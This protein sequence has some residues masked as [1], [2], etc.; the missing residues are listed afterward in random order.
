VAR[1]SKTP[2]IVSS[3][4]NYT[5][6]RKLAKRIGIKPTQLRK[7]QSGEVKPSKSEISKIS[8]L[9]KLIPQE[10]KLK[11][12]IKR[13]KML[14]ISLAE[15]KSAR[16]A[17]TLKEIEQFNKAVARRE[18]KHALTQK[19]LSYEDVRNLTN[20]S[21]YELDKRI[22]RSRIDPN[23]L[24]YNLDGTIS[25]RDSL[26]IEKVLVREQWT[27]GSHPS[28]YVFMRRDVLDA[29]IEYRKSGK[30]T[31]GSEVWDNDAYQLIYSFGV[32]QSLIA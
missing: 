23:T 1:K 4:L 9:N 28:I 26:G 27:D 21:K 32:H 29:Y 18:Y 19:V 11:S 8:H 20:I 16:K 3:L 14:D 7:I 30:R 25:A 22:Q 31:V 24:R 15:V 13:A 2:G 5:T 10:E 6:E 12:N 17:K